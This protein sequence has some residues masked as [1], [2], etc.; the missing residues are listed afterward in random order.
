MEMRMAAKGC[1]KCR[2]K[3]WRKLLNA[4]KMKNL[5]TMSIYVKLRVKLKMK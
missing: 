3:M 5:S 4:R 1:E 2:W